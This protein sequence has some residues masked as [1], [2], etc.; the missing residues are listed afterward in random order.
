MSDERQRPVRVVVAGA[1]GWVGAPLTRAVLAADDL[2]LVGAVSRKR[3]G[4]D[5]GP[6]VG[7]EVG[8]LAV[9]ATLEE[10]LTTEA[11]VVVDYTSPQ[12][13]LDHVELAVRHGLDVVIGTSGLDAAQYAALDG[14]ARSNG[15]AVV[16]AGN[17]SIASAVMQDAV[18]RAARYLR[19][20]EVVEYCDASKPD[21]PSGTATEIAERLARQHPAPPPQPLYGPIEA[22]GARVGGV[23]VHSVRLPG[24]VAST[25]V[26]FGLPHER[27]RFW[28]D[29]G[30]SPDPYVEGTLLAVRQVHRFSGV[31]R[32]LDQLLQ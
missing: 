11:D 16:A 3:A 25:E 29:A 12:A 19:H 24:F 18:L 8:G 14:L 27:V 5:V 6:V 20:Y 28:H 7:A 30:A 9:V 1:S 2:R 23:Q 32:G 10:A 13:V 17:F 4:E 21:V 31:V 26:V 15:V 22:R